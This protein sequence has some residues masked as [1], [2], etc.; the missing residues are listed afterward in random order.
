MCCSSC[1]SAVVKNNG[2]GMPT[3]YNASRSLCLPAAVATLRMTRTFVILNEVKDLHMGTKAFYFA[4]NDKGVR[5]MTMIGWF[6]FGK[7]I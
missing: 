7:K 2:I 1:R 4:Q 5:R 6:G 3:P